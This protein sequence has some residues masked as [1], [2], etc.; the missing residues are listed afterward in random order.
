MIRKLVQVSTI[1]AGLFLATTAFGHHSVSAEFDNTKPVEFTGV[2][3][4]VEWTNPHIYTQ[5]EVKG[6]DGK[7]TMY[8][9]EGTAPNALFRNGWK[10]DSVKPGTTVSFKGIRAKN[11][12]SNN[13]NGKMT[14]PDGK[15]A[16]QGGP[17][18]Y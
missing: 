18:T 6:A 12:A 9:V 3:K 13:V 2:V 16:W 11:P 5:V 4:V 17:A 15:V 10:K 1:T 7:V 8:R 14:L